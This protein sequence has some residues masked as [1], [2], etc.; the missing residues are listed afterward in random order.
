MK[1]QLETLDDLDLQFLA[2]TSKLGQARAKVVRDLCPYRENMNIDVVYKRK[3][4]RANVV[5]VTYYPLSWDN[6]ARHLVRVIVFAY[7]PDGT[8]TH[9]RL[10]GTAP[11]LGDLNDDGFLLPLVV[12]QP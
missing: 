7:F 5:D 6:P 3:T 8:L 12:G 11:L 1:T 9:A 4:A 10:V 2:I